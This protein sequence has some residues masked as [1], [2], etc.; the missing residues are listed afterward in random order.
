MNSIPH[1]PDP[2]CRAWYR[3]TVAARR[4]PA[5]R[6]ARELAFWQRLGGGPR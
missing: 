5:Q 1:L 2:A 3:R 4:T 6:L